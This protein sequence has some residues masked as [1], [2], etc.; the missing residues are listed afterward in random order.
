MSVTTFYLRYSFISL[1]LSQLQLYL[2]LFMSVIALFF[3]FYLRYSFIFLFLSVTALFFSFLSVTA[4]FS[5]FYVSYRFISLFFMSVIA[6]FLSFY[7]SYRFIFLFLCQLQLYLSPF[8]INVF[9]KY[10]SA[11]LPPSHCLIGQVETNS[12]K[13]LQIPSDPG[14]TPDSYSPPSPTVGAN[15]SLQCVSP[16]FLPSFL[17]SSLVHRLLLCPA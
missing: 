4:L 2:S 16:S 12:K 17:P 13:F 7:V 9:S 1:F 11:P 10:S 14:L 6:L 3:S 5:Y 8:C 15:P